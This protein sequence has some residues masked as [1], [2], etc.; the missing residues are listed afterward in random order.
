VINRSWAL[1][2]CAFAL[3]LFA[4]RAAAGPADAVAELLPAD[5]EQFLVLQVKPIIASPAYKKFAAEVV[6]KVLA[7]EEVKEFV[8]KTGID[9]LKD[10]ER[11]VL[12]T[13]PGFNPVKPEGMIVVCGSFDAKKLAVAGL[14]FVVKYKN[15]VAVVKDGPYLLLKITF[16]EGVKKQEW[17][18]AAVDDKRLILSPKQ[19][20]VRAALDRVADKKPPA[21]KDKATLKALAAV[22]PAVA[23]AGRFDRAQLRLLPGLDD[24]A[25]AKLIDKVSYGTVEVRA[26]S[27]LKATLDLVMSDAAAARAMKPTAFQV[28]EQVKTLTGVLTLADARCK[29]LADAARTLQVTTKG[30]SVLIH[31]RVPPEA[32]D[33]LA[34]MAGK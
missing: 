1:A 21:I 14:G 20:E 15:N 30:R 17:Y 8:D 2:S 19:E 27:D 10:V 9:P 11:V 6:K 13:P 29:P 12:A 32:L 26:G 7:R 22:D 34:K 28:A 18:A 33:A 24:P 3:L 25:T 4:G 31:G 23:L 16:G 5:T